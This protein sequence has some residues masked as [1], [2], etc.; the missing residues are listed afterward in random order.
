MTQSKT[1]KPATR[2]YLHQ[3]SVSKGGIPKLPIPQGR[4]GK[5]GVEGDVQR[6]RLLHG[7]VDRAVCLFSL[8]AIEAMQ[9]EGHVIT[10]GAS[11]ENLTL[12]GLDWV[13]LE[14]G[15]RLRIGE[16]VQLEI[17][18]Y[19][20][21]CAQ[22]AG[23]FQGGEFDRISQKKNPGWCRLYAKVLEEGL[24]RPGDPVLVEKVQTRLWTET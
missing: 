19:C 15:D 10:P 13:Q 7:G 21:P 18:S 1:A 4:I 16:T 20:E 12:A 6:N 9:A 8:E 23:C 2:A 22:T 24:V 5:L 11:G 17:K 14:P 3:I